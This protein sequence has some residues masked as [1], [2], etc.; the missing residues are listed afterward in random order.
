[1][2]CPKWFGIRLRDN[3]NYAITTLG[4]IDG[5]DLLLVELKEMK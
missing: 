1:M 4:S 3:V 5:G 2:T